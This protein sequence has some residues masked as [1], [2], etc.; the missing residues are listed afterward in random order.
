MVK[1]HIKLEHG[2]WITILAVLE[3]KAETTI[4]R[5]DALIY[6]ELH[7]KIKHQMEEQIKN[8]KR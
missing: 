4:N 2:S 1:E 6:Q 7:D 5:G 8:D 3:L